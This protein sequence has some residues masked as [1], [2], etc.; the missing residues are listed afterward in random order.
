MISD[1]ES[2]FLNKNKYLIRNMTGLVCAVMLYMPEMDE[3]GNKS[4]ILFP[5]GGRWSPHKVSQ[6]LISLS[7]HVKKSFWLLFFE[8]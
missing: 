5:L 4:Y 8:L 6:C 1:N 7:L 3:W 2:V